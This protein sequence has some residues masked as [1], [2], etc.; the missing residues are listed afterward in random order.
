MTDD[1]TYID[2]Y[3]KA[4]SEISCAYA[5]EHGVCEVL[6]DYDTCAYCTLTPCPYYKENTN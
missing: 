4:V 1:K 2:E 6:S 5:D 3:E